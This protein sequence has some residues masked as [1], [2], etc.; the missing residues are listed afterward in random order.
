MILN[1]DGETY[2]VVAK[3]NSKSVIWY[4]PTSLKE[5]GAQTPETW[6]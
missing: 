2:G 4:K 1:I 5:L 3:A 6:D